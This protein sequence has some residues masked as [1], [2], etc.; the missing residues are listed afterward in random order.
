MI[1]WTV[2]LILFSSCASTDLSDSSTS[3]S[4]PSWYVRPQERFPPAEYMVAVGSGS[5]EEAAVSNALSELMGQ[6]SLTVRSVTQIHH[7][8]QEEQQR[9]TETVD[10][11]TD[12]QLQSSE[13]LFIGLQF[14][15]EYRDSVWYVAAYLA[16]TQVI[17][18]YL[19]LI[20]TEYRQLQELLQKKSE[21]SVRAQ[22]VRYLQ[23]QR[24]SPY[25]SLLYQQLRIISP[26]AAA[27]LPPFHSE[28]LLRELYDDL[29]PRLTVR[30]ES[31]EQF[32]S[33]ALSEVMT[34][35]GF[36]VRK[37]DAEF[38]LTAELRSDESSG[39]KYHTVKW[40]LN[41]QFQTREGET[42]LTWTV[43]DEDRNITASLASERAVQHI[44][45]VIL[46]E[47][48]KSSK[49]ILNYNK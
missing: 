46:T 13:Q 31:N 45:R 28:S 39:E 49:N 19:L 20:E 8:Y 25:L 43:R 14:E 2:L 24:I 30:I 37:D 34:S 48:V 22:Y 11:R 35:D 15:K 38:L 5:T 10:E 1:L 16:R 32:V 29:A 27:S 18:R 41:V 47:M 21:E 3:N 23:A 6:F 12:L 40:L 44:R 7:R 33:E 4:I 42:I 26:A 9:G 17:P 36:R